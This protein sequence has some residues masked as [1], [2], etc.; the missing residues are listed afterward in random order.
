VRGLSETPWMV[1]WVRRFLCLASL[2]S[3]I[4]VA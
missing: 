4:Q 1:I 2:L 3:G